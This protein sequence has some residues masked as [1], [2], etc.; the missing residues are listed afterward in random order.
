MR[1][2][3]PVCS[4]LWNYEAALLEHI[5][6]AH[7]RKPKGKFLAELPINSR[8][9]RCYDYSLVCWCGWDAFDEMVGP[10]I[11]EDFSMAIIASGL[12]LERAGGV[13]DH[14]LNWRL[15]HMEIV[16]P[17]HLQVSV[18]QVHFTAEGGFH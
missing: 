6:K 1:H 12:H 10:F 3:C 9:E 5:I 18:H 7:F 4:R 2:Q 17:S 14:W 13:Q 16:L 15:E 8:V 11:K